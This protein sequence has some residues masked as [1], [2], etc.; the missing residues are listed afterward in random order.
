M[1]S[2]INLSER[3]EAEIEGGLYKNIPT[4]NQ[5][6]EVVVKQGTYIFLLQTNKESGITKGRCGN[7]YI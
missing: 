6:A 3:Q 4:F 5:K 1:R 2:Q 7:I